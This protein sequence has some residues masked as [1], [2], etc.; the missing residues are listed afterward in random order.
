MHA[1]GGG[2]SYGCIGVATVGEWK[3]VQKLLSNTSQSTSK[4][5]RFK[6][7]LSINI[8]KYGD[9]TVTQSQKITVRD[10]YAP[11][12]CRQKYIHQRMH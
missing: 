10:R 7:L 5:D 3:S 8:Q 2:L 9:L 1:P 12:D 11:K 4:V 6:G